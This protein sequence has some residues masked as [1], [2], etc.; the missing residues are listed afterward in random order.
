MKSR[1]YNLLGGYTVTFERTALGI[2]CEWSPRVPRGR[3]GKRVL[4]H[5]RAAR[6]EWLYGL[7]ASVMVVEL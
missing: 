7:G 3:K 4:P 1:P 5:Y 2:N 6:D